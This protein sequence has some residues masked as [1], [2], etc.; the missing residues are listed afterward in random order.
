MP[1]YVW[2]FWQFHASIIGYFA[3]ISPFF[4][5]FFFFFFFLIQSK[6]AWVLLSFQKLKVGRV[7]ETAK[8]D[9]GANL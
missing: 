1:D 5:S 8:L 4:F 2:K 9:Y 7:L 6:G 3:E